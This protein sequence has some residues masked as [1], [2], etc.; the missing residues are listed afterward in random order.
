M[1][2]TYMYN[3][4]QF[5]N[6]LL[7][8]QANNFLKFRTKCSHELF[9]NLTSTS[10]EIHVPLTFALVQI[11]NR[12]EVRHIL[13]R[14]FKV[15]L[16][17]SVYLAGWLEYTIILKWSNRFTSNLGHDNIFFNLTASSKMGCL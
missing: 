15:Y 14:P 2:T 11:F 8:V 7:F 10:I 17:I 6:S 1:A 13:F 9:I 16:A 4:N 12:S 5:L 3:L